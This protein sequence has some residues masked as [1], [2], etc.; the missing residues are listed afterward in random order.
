MAKTVL[1]ERTGVIISIIQRSQK[2]DKHEEMRV[3]VS[4]IVCER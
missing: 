3:T 4:R 1:E 2:K